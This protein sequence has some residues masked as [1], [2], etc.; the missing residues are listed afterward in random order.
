MKD[1]IPMLVDEE[2][3]IMCFMTVRTTETEPEHWHRLAWI[4]FP[5]P[6]KLHDSIY[7]TV[8]TQTLDPTIE[9]LDVNFRQEAF[10]A[11][12]DFYDHDID[13]YFR[14]N[15]TSIFDYKKLVMNNFFWTASDTERF[16]ESV[17]EMSPNL[18]LLEDRAT[19]LEW[20]K[21][22]EAVIEEHDH[23]SR[24]YAYE[25]NDVCSF[26]LLYDLAEYQPVR[27]LFPFI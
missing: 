17:G 5:P 20:T 10:F 7:N 18:K 4:N 19:H 12:I 9:F 1:L 11:E 2:N 25:S 26:D 24:V 6:L 13:Q 15:F 27:F 14:S 22:L 16:F 3:D 8:H 21:S 23:E